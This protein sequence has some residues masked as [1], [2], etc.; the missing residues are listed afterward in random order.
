ML[1][2]E[3]FLKIRAHTLLSFVQTQLL[4]LSAQASGSVRVCY[5]TGGSS[6]LFLG[7][8]GQADSAIIPLWCATLNFHSKLHLSANGSPSCCHIHSE[9]R[10]ATHLMTSYPS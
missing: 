3:I 4:P 6:P 7:L 9:I 2:R 8:N 5:H 10:D 1:S